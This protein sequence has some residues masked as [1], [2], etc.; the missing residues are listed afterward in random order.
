MDPALADTQLNLTMFAALSSGTI[1]GASVV[2]KEGEKQAL[3][4]Y[5]IAVLI[6]F[7]LW[8]PFRW[9]D[10]YFLNILSKEDLCEAYFIITSW[11]MD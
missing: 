5:L 9:L 6:T 10:P 3:P 1:L 2:L 7:V 8:I 4:I 11:M